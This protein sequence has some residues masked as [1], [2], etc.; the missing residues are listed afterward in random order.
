MGC[1]I[2]WLCDAFQI[3]VMFYWP[4]D[5]QSN[6]VQFSAAFLWQACTHLQFFKNLSFYICFCLR[7]AKR[8]N[9][10]NTKKESTGP[11]SDQH[12]RLEK[13]GSRSVPSGLNRIVPFDDL[14]ELKMKTLSPEREPEVAASFNQTAAPADDGCSL[15]VRPMYKDLTQLDVHHIA[16][17]LTLFDADLLQKIQCHELSNCAWIHKGRVWVPY[18]NNCC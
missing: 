15:P 18:Y 9:P 14:E 4:D 8:R 5:V 10:L 16:E 6:L 17:E 2:D 3:G 7:L 1:I 11:L 12:A 13:I